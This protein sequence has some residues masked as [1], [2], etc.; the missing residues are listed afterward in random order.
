MKKSF[1]LLL[2][3]AIPAIAQQKEQNERY[4]LYFQPSLDQGNPVT[5]L[6]DTQTGNAWKLGRFDSLGVSADSQPPY[7]FENRTYYVWIPVLFEAYPK[8]VHGYYLL[9]PPPSKK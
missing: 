5:I 4:H 6:L 1:V 3:L 2:F 9:S 8:M 7:T